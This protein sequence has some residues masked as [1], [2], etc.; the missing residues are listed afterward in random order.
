MQP[1]SRKVQNAIEF[2]NQLLGIAD[3]KL[4]SDL[5]D[6]HTPPLT[7]MIVIILNLF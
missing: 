1:S 7:M 5:K 4:K 2:I 3:N 6:M